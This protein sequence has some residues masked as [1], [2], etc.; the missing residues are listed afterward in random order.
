MSDSLTLDDIT[1]MMTELR[2]YQERTVVIKIGGNAIAEDDFFLS[3]IAQQILFLS[4]NGLRVVVVHGGGPQIDEAMREHNIE[5]KKAKDGRRITSPKAM[6]I[7]VRVMNKVNH[8]VVDALVEAGVRK[9][10]IY[11][12]CAHKRP[13]V[14]AESID[15]PNA[16]TNRSGRPLK[17]NV[18]PIERALDDGKIAILHSLGIGTDNK[19][20]Y[21]TNGDDFAMVVAR[22]LRAKRLILVTNVVGVLDQNHER[23]PAI[24]A[25]MAK[26]LIKDGVITGGMVPKVESAIALTKQGVNGVA[27]I[28]GF[29]PWS[30]LA[31]ILTHQGR[32]TLFRSRV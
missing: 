24:D 18:E 10:K 3:K 25:L 1:E 12:S 26:Q 16:K 5:V 27:I 9:Q 31:E 4:T 15:P 2:S 14:Q 13:L 7:V 21:N 22:D 19:T 30:I 17:T 23:I 28:D 6:R 8:M 32:G 20:I 11:A 29:H